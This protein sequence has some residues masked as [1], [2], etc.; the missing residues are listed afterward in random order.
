MGKRAKES[1]KLLP[2]AKRRADDGAAAD[3]VVAAAPDPFAGCLNAKIQHTLCCYDDKVIQH[4]VFEG[5]MLDQATDYSGVVAHDPDEAKKKLN[6]GQD[7]VASC[8]FFWLNLR[9]E[10]QPNVPKYWVRIDNLRKHFFTKPAMFPDTL[11]IA[12]VRGEELPHVRQGQLCAVCPPEMRD[13]LRVAMGMAAEEANH[14]T[15]REWREVVQSIPIRFMVT[16]PGHSL[17]ITFQCL[18]QKREDL[19]VKNDNMRMSSLLRSYEVMDLK[20][21][22]EDGGPKQNK[23]TLAEYYSQL[24]LA[25]SSEKVSPTFVE[26]TLTLHNQVLSV[27]EVSEICFRFDQM[28]NQNPWTAWRSTRRSAPNATRRVPS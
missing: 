10:A 21:Q 2:V 13:A 5:I 18:V 8:P 9:Y 17:N 11:T 19:A 16:D 25:A 1:A 14:A 24:T 15:L 22:L 3:G 6:A 28:G 27:K 12:H 4:Q 7:Y 26:N 23:K 20:K